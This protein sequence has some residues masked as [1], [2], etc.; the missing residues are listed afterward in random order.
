M[1]NRIQVTSDGHRA[2]IKAVQGAFGN[3]IDYAMLVK[4]Y[5]GTDTALKRYSSAECVGGE[6]QRIIGRP[7]PRYII[8]SYVER[9]YLTPRM[10]NRRFARSTNALSKK[11]G[12][13]IASLAIHYMHYNFVR[14]Y[15]TLRMTP[16]MAAGVT[17]HLWDVEDLI[18]ILE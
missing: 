14:I 3:D 2:Y 4:I 17:A 5:G 9:Q 7:N 12:S 11:L 1:A 6:R 18:R 16:A 15:Q 8:R 10:Q 13:H